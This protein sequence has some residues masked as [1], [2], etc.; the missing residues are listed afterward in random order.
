[1][2]IWTELLRQNRSEMTDRTG[3]MTDRTGIE[4]KKSLEK[5]A[6]QN[7]TILAG[8]GGLLSKIETGLIRQDRRGGTERRG[9]TGK[10]RKYRAAKK[11]LGRTTLTR[12]L[13]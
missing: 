9:Q 13:K 3:G 2:C 7:N 1:M 10:V 12:I 8:K 11:D 6:E 4:S 5:D